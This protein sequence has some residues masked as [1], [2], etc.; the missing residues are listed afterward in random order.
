[1]THPTEH[2]NYLFLPSDSKCPPFTVICCLCTST[3]T[4]TRTALTYPVWLLTNTSSHHLQ[5][6]CLLLK[7]LWN[8]LL[9]P[10]HGATTL[11]ESPA[12][13]SSVPPNSEN[14]WCP[15]E[16]HILRTTKQEEFLRFPPTLSSLHNSTN[17]S[18]SEC[19]FLA[20]K[21]ADFRS[22]SP[23]YPT[24]IKNEKWALHEPNQEYCFFSCFSLTLRFLNWNGGGRIIRYDVWEIDS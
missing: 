13:P 16:D 22:F 7:P 6:L 2:W 23:F 12:L 19:S 1:M 17:F 5:V 4:N 3:G 20:I 8:P 9:P 15:L 11:A 10:G 21:E 18:F 24:V 14:P